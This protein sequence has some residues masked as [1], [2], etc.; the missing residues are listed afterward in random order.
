MIIKMPLSPVIHLCENCR[1]IDV[2]NYC[3]GC[4]TWIC[5]DCAKRHVC[6]TDKRKIKNEK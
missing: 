4:K 2:N 5:K 1:K 6:K 3:T